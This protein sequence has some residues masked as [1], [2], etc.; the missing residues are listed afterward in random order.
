MALRGPI[1]LGFLMVAVIVAAGCAGADKTS[2]T[3]PDSASLAPADA[4][5]Y[6]TLTT[7][8]GSSQWEKAEKVLERIPGA[9]DGLAGVI[10]G[11]LAEEGLTWERDIAPALGPELVI[12]ATADLKP[13]V[14]VQ[15]E[16]DE[17]LTALLEKGDEEFVR[18]KAD[19]WVA[20]AQTEAD[21]RAYETARGRGTLADN[22]ALRAGLEALPEESLG[23]VWIDFEAITGRLGELQ[24]S[25]P[26]DFDLGVEWMSM[27]LAAEDTGMLFAMGLRMPGGGDSRYEP[28]LF[29]EVPEDAVAAI[30]F[31]GTQGTL[32]R[33]R[34]GASLDDI[35]REVE[36]ATGVSLDRLVDA[37]S[38]EGVVYVRNGNGRVP[39]VTIALRP[40]DA[41]ETFATLD[42][43]ARKVA[44]QL[45]TQV[46]TATEFGAE[47][48]SLEI[49][50]VVVKY[51]RAD[52]STIVVTTGNSAF[53]SLT[54]D[55]PKLVD[56]DGY[57]RASE[58]VGGL[59]GPT[60]GF[61]YVDVDGLLPLVESIAGGEAVPPDVREGVEAFDSFILEASGEGDTTTVRGFLRVNE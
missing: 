21:L 53:A 5:V 6:A 19:D 32:D 20:L 57:Q 37:L 59:E 34:G 46:T 15:P 56:S 54:G 60:K 2:S 52:A 26:Q 22:Q 25:L 28:E 58:D 33:L 45:E 24:E 38:G 42:R 12:V 51:G 39:D 43:V 4:I 27:A 18:G 16:D 17:K 50:D 47:V 49:E 30:S 36:Q 7:D 14:L 9:R 61:V 55:G 44:E 40:P 8:D 35:S 41:D 13:V 29:A 10:E 1:A 23:K 31:G 48:S 11:S 3:V